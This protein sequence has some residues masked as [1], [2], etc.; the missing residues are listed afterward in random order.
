ME[1]DKAVEVGIKGLEGAGFMEGVEVLDKSR[2]LHTEIDALDNRAERIEGC[3]VWERI[4]GLSVRHGF[5]ADKVQVES[6]S[7]EEVREL[8]PHVAGKGGLGTG[9]ENEESDWWGGCANLGDR[10]AGTGE[11]GMESVA[12]GWKTGNMLVS[13]SES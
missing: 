3:A 11:E 8:I 13:I 7:W 2:D 12:E 1:H 6:R 5:G 4:L 10:L 9:A